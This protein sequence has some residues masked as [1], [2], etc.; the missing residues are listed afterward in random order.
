MS[1]PMKI[2]GNAEFRFG[3]Y[4]VW[5]VADGIKWK[6][7]TV[8]STLGT[9]GMYLDLTAPI[10]LYCRSCEPHHVHLNLDDE[11]QDYQDTNS[12]EGVSGN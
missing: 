8:G 3:L 10:S 4:Y 9:V 11:W 1:G 5:I 2:R 7:T 12:E 6:K